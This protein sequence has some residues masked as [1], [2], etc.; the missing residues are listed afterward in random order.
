MIRRSASDSRLRFVNT[1]YGDGA[2]A[3]DGDS[4]PAALVS[5]VDPIPPAMWGL[6]SRGGYDLEN[7]GA[8]LRLL[9]N[10]HKYLDNAKKTY[11]P[12][13]ISS[14]LEDG[15]FSALCFKCHA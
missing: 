8:I 11:R 5:P 6:R 4:L 7:P 13:V 9:R 12:G 2:V 14:E 15:L 3:D 10:A 1:S